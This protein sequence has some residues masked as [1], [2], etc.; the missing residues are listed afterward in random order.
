M[1]RERRVRRLVIGD[2]TWWWTVRHRHPDCREVL[3]L[4]H[5][6][7]GASLRVVFRP[8]PGRL[9]P[10]GFMPSGSVGTS[11]GRCLNLHEPGVVR[12]F[13]DAAVRRSFEPV[14]R[15]DM[16]IDGWPLFDAVV[17]ELPDAAER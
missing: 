5:E 10:D 2:T 11:G 15:R 7:T 12:L 6:P 9:V 16:T 1:S 14:A 13:A 3:S 4:H 8:G 17:D